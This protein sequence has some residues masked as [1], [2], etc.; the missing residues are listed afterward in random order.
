M[1]LEARTRLMSPA[2]Y[3][4]HKQLIKDTSMFGELKKGE[5][6]RKDLEINPKEVA[7]SRLTLD[8]GVEGRS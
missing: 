7:L 5:I 3:V 2:L 1:E 4:I 6:N 8:N